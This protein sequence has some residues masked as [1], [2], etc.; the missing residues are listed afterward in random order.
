MGHK[1]ETIWMTA[2]RKSLDEM[3]SKMKI[4]D[5]AMLAKAGIYREKISIYQTRGNI[6][7]SVNLIACLILFRLPLRVLDPETGD[8]WVLQFSVESTQLP[9]P[10]LPE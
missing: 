9:L 8:A 3:M 7:N 6:P 1:R 4:M 2:V 10:L 5:R